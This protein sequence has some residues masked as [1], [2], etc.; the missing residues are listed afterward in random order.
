MSRGY[1]GWD[2]PP[3]SRDTDSGRRS[4]RRRGS[5]PDDDRRQADE[6]GSDEY[7]EHGD[8][9]SRPYAGPEGYG[10]D[11]YG[12]DYRGG[13]Q[14]AGY[15]SG[16]QG[17]YG[18]DGYAGQG[19]DGGGYADGY[20]GGYAENGYSGDNPENGYGGDDPDA[21]A[22]R[23]PYAS[24]DPYATG[25]YGPADP[26]AGP[27][28]RASGP[29]GLT[30]P[31][32]STD[33]YRR[34]RDPYDTGGGGYAGQ[35]SYAGQDG[36]AGHDPYA[37][38]P[39]GGYDRGSY[40]QQD[41]DLYRWRDAPGAGDDPGLTRR[42]SASR[43]GE[44]DA[45]DPRHDGFFRGFGGDDDLGGGGRSRSRSRG[46]G[47][48]P[49]RG[50]P[51]KQRKSHAGLVALG[52]VLAVIA[53]VAYTGYHYYSLYKARHATYVGS[54]YGHTLITVKNGDTLDGISSQLLRK[55]VIAAIDPWASFVAN[56]SGQL[57]PG[58][59]RI[60]IHM[61]PAAAFA[62]LMNQKN[63]INSKVTIVPG[64]RV[65]DILPALARESGIPLSQFQAAIKN[66]AQLGLPA[67]AHGNPEGYL[68]PDTYS[69]APGETALKILQTAVAQF[70]SEVAS[71]HLVAAANQAQ[72]TPAQVITGA[73]LLEAEVSSKYFAD[74]ARVIDNRLNQGMALQMDSTVAYALGVH[75][76][77]L[78]TSQLNVNSPYNTRMNKG[79]PPGPIDSPDIT[80]ILAFLHPAPHSSTTNSWLYFVTVDK[81]G[82]TYFTGSYSQFLTWQ[83]LAKRNGVI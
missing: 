78:T 75:T 57:H 73:S 66:T 76:D 51:P 39:G 12:G 60:H 72:F 25:D 18:D 69:I 74:V 27:D 53:G 35:D 58:T 14:P 52:V 70:N 37:S 38:S 34:G 80:A 59:Y 49:S 46:G 8:Y 23:D 3:R 83:A 11:G 29:H 36:F 62:A 15:G 22:A 5:G 33:P 28:P 9:G 48:S 40:E 64:L 13:D 65:T 79:L 20:G 77:K 61:S 45:E 54:G 16:Y 17:G 63:L 10:T 43:E 68:Y 82:T 2:S 30:D 44:F 41:D 7:T 50:R 31:R 21:Y 67:Y 71:I 4:H 6:Y 56:K 1:E 19:Y 55:G 26:Y 42:R 24:R 47:R 81:N 32:A